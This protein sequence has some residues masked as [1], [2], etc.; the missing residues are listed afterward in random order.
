[1]KKSIRPHISAKVRERRL[2]E[3]S[4]MRG[5]G[6]SDHIVHLIDSW[7]AGYHLYIQTE[8]CEEGNLEAFLARA[9]QKDRLDDFRI[10]KILTE[11]CSVSHPS[12]DTLLD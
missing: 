12:S 1:M 8:F 7:E 9:G 3:V 6:K 11:L 2:E 10:W 4:I 5:L